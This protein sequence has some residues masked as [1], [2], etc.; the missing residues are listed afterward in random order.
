MKSLPCSIG[1]VLLAVL[2]TG[3]ASWPPWGQPEDPLIAETCTSI[4]NITEKNYRLGASMSYVLV[5]LGLIFE[6]SGVTLTSQMAD[7]QIDQ[8]RICRLRAKGKISEESWLQASLAFATAS[9]AGASRTKDP[10][11][12]RKLKENLADLQVQVRKISEIGPRTPEIRGSVTELDISQVIADAQLVSDTELSARLKALNDK[13][14]FQA[15]SVAT[16]REQYEKSQKA[17]DEQDFRLL[18]TLAALQKQVETLRSASGPITVAGAQQLAW[19]QQQTFRI[20]FDL[21][22]SNLS[23]RAKLT[24]RSA[25]S[26]LTHSEDYRVELFGYTDTSGSAVTNAALS[27]A[28]AQEARDFL[29]DMVQL[30]PSKILAVG[31]QRGVSKFGSPKENRVVEV[32]VFVLGAPDA[33]AEAVAPR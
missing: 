13:F 10:E 8:D 29:M 9:S 7:H 1:G 4:S 22:S 25:L 20:G 18:G 27:M 16:L 32:R 3:C 6:K 12:L 33:F 31:R 19:R 26:E 24:L 17:R 28:R 2:V 15:D 11:V 5:G 23:E 21:G 14:G 30:E